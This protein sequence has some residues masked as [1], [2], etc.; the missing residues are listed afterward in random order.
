MRAIVLLKSRTIVFCFVTYPG[1][2][3]PCGT[4]SVSRLLMGCILKYII[5]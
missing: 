3:L 1:H 5:V 4:Y 2:W